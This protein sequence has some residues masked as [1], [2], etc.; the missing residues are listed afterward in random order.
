MPSWSKKE[1]FPIIERIIKQICYK[2]GSASR[3]QIASALLEDSQ[4]Q[5]IIE[6]NLHTRNR[7]AF[8]E[9][10]NIVDWFSA[11]FTKRLRIS[12]SYIDLF[13][14]DECPSFHPES[15][16]LRWVKRYSLVCQPEKLENY[17]NETEENDNIFIEGALTTITVNSYERNGKAREQCLEYYGYSCFICGFDFY[18]RYGYVG[19]DY[20]HVHHLKPLSQIRKTYVVDPMEDLRPV[21]ANCHA[22]IHRRNPPFTPEEVKEFIALSATA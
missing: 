15:D 8:D 16:R 7:A 10:G 13:K 14:Q 5:Q 4:G 21:C 3:D 19:K 18:Q 11:E 17:P 12:R 2:H 22:I 9:A 6:R 1:V 20:I